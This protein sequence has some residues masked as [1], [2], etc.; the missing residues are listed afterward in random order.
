MCS[1]RTSVDVVAW[2]VRLPTGPCLLLLLLLH[3]LM[4]LLAAMLM[5]PVQMMHAAEEGSEAAFV[6]PLLQA[7]NHNPFGAQRPDRGLE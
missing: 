5:G 7:L 2:S 4:L 3:V 1:K 6:L